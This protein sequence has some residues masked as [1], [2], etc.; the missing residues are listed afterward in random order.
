MYCGAED[1]TAEDSQPVNE[2]TRAA[3]LFRQTFEEQVRCLHLVLARASAWLP[4]V[5][6]PKSWWPLLSLQSMED[7]SNTSRRD[8]QQSCQGK[9]RAASRRLEYE[10]AAP[11]AH[12]TSA[13][14]KQVHC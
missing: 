3:Q 7:S 4:E 8:D 12:A 2:A 9:Q 11:R 5:S 6:L 1:T 13:M 14:H 10:G